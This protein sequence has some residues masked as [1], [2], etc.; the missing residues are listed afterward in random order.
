MKQ[1]HAILT[2][3]GQSIYLN[4]CGLRTVSAY[5]AIKYWTSR[6]AAILWLQG[7]VDN[8]T[9]ELQRMEGIPA[10][11]DRVSQWRNGYQLVR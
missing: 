8:T 11:W 10:C 4:H 9:Y 1:Y 7:T 3:Q 2:E 5:G 6:D